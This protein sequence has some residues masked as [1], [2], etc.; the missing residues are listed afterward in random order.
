[1]WRS[2]KKE[3]DL[4]VLTAVGTVESRVVVR[5]KRGTTSV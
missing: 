1:L 2:E 4:I 3:E 5:R